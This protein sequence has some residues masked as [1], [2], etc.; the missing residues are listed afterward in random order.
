MAQ[1]SYLAVRSER[2]DVVAL[3]LDAEPGAVRVDVEH[4]PRPLP[5]AVSLVS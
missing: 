2:A 5:P 1:H 4:P 3:V